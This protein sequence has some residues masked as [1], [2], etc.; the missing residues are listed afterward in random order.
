MEFSFNKIQASTFN[1]KQDYVD[2]IL[3]CNIA[4]NFNCIPVKIMWWSKVY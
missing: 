4:L 1:P 2:P 3:C